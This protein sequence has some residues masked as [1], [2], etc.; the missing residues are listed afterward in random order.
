ME[1]AATCPCSLQIIPAGATS[2]R[3]CTGCAG[4]VVKW[5]M[6]KPPIA[7]ANSATTRVIL[8]SD[9]ARLYGVPA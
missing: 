9:F 3:S 2:N 8:D 1:N 5:I 4:G 6:R 7:P